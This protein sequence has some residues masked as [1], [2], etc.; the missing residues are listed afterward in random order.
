MTAEDIDINIK[1][2]LLD[3]GIDFILKGIDELF[4]DKHAIWG[5]TNPLE[6][7]TNRY[8]YG[9]LHLFS[10][11]LLLL[12]ERL[13]RHLPELIFRGKI[14]EVKKKMAAGNIPNTV[15]L[16]EAL[17]RL[18]IGPRV[19]FSE[20]GIEVIRDMQDI[21]NRFEHYEMSGNKYQLWKTVSEF[22]DLVDGF[23]VKELQ[24][25]IE[26]SAATIELRTKIQ[27]IEAIWTRVRQQRADEWEQHAQSQLEK[28]KPIREDI[29]E[30]LTEE[31]YL[32]K[33]DIIPFI[34]CP[35]CGQETLIAYGEFTGICANPDCY[36]INPIAACDRCGNLMTGFSWN[37]NLCEYC[38]MD[39]ERE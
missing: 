18:E 26:Q 27:S 19:T 12:K 36:S 29:V 5:Y 38:E 25:N 6:V 30:G 33:G 7:T 21:R 23:L 3:N 9:T 32:S 15:D 4:D 1:L 28:L 11:F 22:L 24:V 20:K 10:G 16:D 31:P 14:G 37:V 17:E 13:S 35:E 39:I 2:S 8:K 34:F